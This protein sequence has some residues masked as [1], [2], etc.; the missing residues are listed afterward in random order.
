MSLSPVRIVNLTRLQQIVDKDS[1]ATAE[2]Y[3]LCLMEEVG[4]ISRTIL[5][6]KGIKHKKNKQSLKSEVVDAILCSLGLYLKLSQDGFDDIFTEIADEKM[7]KWE[8][9]LDTAKKLRQTA[10]N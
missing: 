1:E 8:K 2:D 3:L 10:D 6:E 7:S 4:E 9:R 5:E